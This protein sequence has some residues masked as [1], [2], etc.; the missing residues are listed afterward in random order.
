M[1]INDRGKIKWQGAFFQPEHVKML[2]D[3]RTD[4]YRTAKPELDAYQ[5]NEID[6]QICEAMAHNLPIKAVVWENGFTR[7]LK[8]MVHYIDPLTQE[9]RIEIKPGEYERIKFEEII[10]IVVM[11]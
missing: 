8:G 5:L 2:G 10:N 9:L 11:D 4:Y 3:L 7:D 6:E 1:S